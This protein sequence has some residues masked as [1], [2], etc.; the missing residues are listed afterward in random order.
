[1]NHAEK[2]L[3]EP[4]DPLTRAATVALWPVWTAWTFTCAATV[5]ACWLRDRMLRQR[6]R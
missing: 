2:S 4:T 3:E 6:P 5:A 1:M